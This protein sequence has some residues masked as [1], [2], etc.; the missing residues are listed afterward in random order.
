MGSTVMCSLP[1]CIYNTTESMLLYTLQMHCPENSKQISPNMKLRGFIPNVYI[2]VSVSDLYI[3]D[4]WQQ[5]YNKLGG[6]IVVI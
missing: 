6:S 1:T 4:P 5:Q 2:H 3:H